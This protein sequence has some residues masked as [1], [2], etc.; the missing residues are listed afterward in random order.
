M[1]DGGDVAYEP[2]TGENS[3]AIEQLRDQ[4]REDLHIYRDDLRS[5]QRTTDLR[6]DR[7]V[8]TDVYAADRRADQFRLD[9][10]RDELLAKITSLQAAVTSMQSAKQDRAANRKWVIA[11]VCIP[12]GVA[13]LEVFFTIRGVK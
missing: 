3:R 6:L 8:P 1:G 4:I 9:A 7:T 10:V 12:I 5:F 13:I 11:A 2:T